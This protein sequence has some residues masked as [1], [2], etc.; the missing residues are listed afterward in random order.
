MYSYGLSTPYYQMFISFHDEIEML[1]LAN[2]QV[3]FLLFHNLF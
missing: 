1:I 2:T 3:A